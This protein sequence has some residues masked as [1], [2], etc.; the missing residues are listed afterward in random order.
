MP[1]I[2]RAFPRTS[3]ASFVFFVVSLLT[4]PI[5]AA[6]Q[7]TREVAYDS[8]AV[9]RVNAKVRFTTLIILPETEEILDFVCGDKDFWVVSGPQT[10]AYVKPAKAGA[11]TNLNLVTASGNVYSFLL[12]EGPGEA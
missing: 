1:R 11:S 12:A 8:H 7:T 4:L 6:A 5:P 2:V 10:L 3:F 9:V